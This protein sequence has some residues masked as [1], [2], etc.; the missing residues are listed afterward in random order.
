MDIARRFIFHGHAC[1]YS[2]RLYR[3]EDIVINSP[4]STAVSV[5][6][7]LSE[8]KGGRQRFGAYLSVGKCRAS[9][10]ASFD[11]R[12]QAVAMSHGRVGEDALAS[13]TTSIVEINDIVAD[14]KRL[15]VGQIGV[16]LAAAAPKSGRSAIRLGRQ[17][18]VRDVSIDDVT[19]QVTLDVKRFNQADSFDAASRLGPAKKA[20]IFD[21]YEH[22]IFTTIVSELKWKGKPHPTAVIEGHGVHVPGMGRIYFGE[23]VIERDARRVTMMRLHLGS[24]IG[25]RVGFGDVGTNGSWY[26]PV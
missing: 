17:T 4:A 8:A 15:R 24:P 25:L 14:S 5:S 1:A 6:G 10:A 9:T 23:V 16:A 22:V 12:K 18:A 26:P 20:Q 13:T 2:G 19:L 3:P 21:V 11:D 7:G